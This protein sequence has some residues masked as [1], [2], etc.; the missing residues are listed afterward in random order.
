MGP[1]T[2]TARVIQHAKRTLIAAG[3]RGEG[4]FASAPEHTQA[5]QRG[6][7]IKVDGPYGH[8]TPINDFEQIILVGG[9]IGITPCSA[10]LQAIQRQRRQVDHS[11][12]PGDTI[13]SAAREADLQEPALLGG[14]ASGDRHAGG[15]SGG[16]GGGSPPMMYSGTGVRRV[17]VLW[18]LRDAYLVEGLSEVLSDLVSSSRLSNFD[19]KDSSLQNQSGTAAAAY[20]PDEH[21]TIY[22]TQ[23]NCLN[24]T[25]PEGFKLVCSR[26]DYN[27]EFARLLQ[28]VPASK[29]LVFACG[30]STMVESALQAAMELG[31]HF[32]NE[33]FEL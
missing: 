4:V 29:T 27:V 33:T 16:G 23:K 22:C 8:G 28:S 2:W 31:C 15:G 30:P 14:G 7:I 1:A 17:S 3:V 9:G 5:I 26:P 18:S 20:V 10:I 6:F 13:V 21:N 24:L 25:L 11:G 12:F 32:H 19:P